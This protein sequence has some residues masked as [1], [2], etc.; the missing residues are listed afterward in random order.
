MLVSRVRSL[1][2]V[3][4]AVIP[5]V[6]ILSGAGRAG[7]QTTGVAV[8]RDTEVSVDR[9]GSLRQPSTPK[10]YIQPD[11]QIEPSIAVNPGNPLDVVAGYQE[12]RVDV[13]GD[14]TNGWATSLDGGRT[15]RSGEVPGLTSY[16]G[17]G[18]PFD[19]ASDAVVAFGPADDVYFS[20][21]V[22]DDSTEQGL[23]SGMAVNVSRDG[24]LTWS[25]PVFFA[26][27]LLGDLND[28]NWVV[29]DRSGA[30]GHHRGRV[31]VFWDRVGAMFYDYC[32]Q[33]CDQLSGWAFGGTFQQVD[34][35]PSYIGQDIGAT[36]VVENDG[37]LAV[38]FNS[39]AG[40]VPN[41]AG[42]VTGADPTATVR[43]TCIV[44]PLA[45]TQPFGTPLVFEPPVT[46]ADNL[47]NQ[48]RSQRAAGLPSADY[49]SR[50]STIWVAWED[51]RHHTEAYPEN[52]ILVASS[53]DGGS[54]WTA[55]A[56]VNPSTPTD[57]VDRYNASIAAGP[58]GTVH[59]A[60]RQRQEADD[61]ARFSPNIDTMYQSSSDGVHWSAPLQVNQV[62]D[63][64]RYGAFS[65]LGTFQGDYNGIAAGG[66]VAY[67]VRAESYP[68]HRS[69]PVA[70]TLAPTSSQPDQMALTGRGHQ[71]QR[72]WVAVVGRAGSAAAA[73]TPAPAPGPTR[74]PGGGSG[75]GAPPA[76]TLP[77]TAAAGGATRS[78]SAIALAAL[79]GGLGVAW[80][81]RRRRR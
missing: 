43:L 62:V 51:A 52:D 1:V 49:D 53:S 78:V 76:T 73:G 40:G 77:D 23:P 14:A 56:K 27:D 80:A 35:V 37:S 38:V 72:I 60:Y 44:A 59:V 5:A 32:D 55:P 34:V 50:T 61:P 54:T 29:V 26:S 7:A 15:W 6:A 4:A 12:G 68:L 17:Q 65:R 58:D 70:L 79:G 8:L 20:S 47:S 31:Y 33:S 16:P 48:P 67:V 36:P 42:D 3:A 22:F 11:T 45:G 28:K 39:A 13:G 81:R 9:L 57:H 19:R 74:T 66:S 63:D 75:P 46:I 24:G 64:A 69:E 21:L 18:G 71:H 2:V 30:A 41:S 10:D 25:K